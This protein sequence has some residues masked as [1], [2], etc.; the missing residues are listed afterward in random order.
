[1]TNDDTWQHISEIADDLIRR[2]EKAN[3]RTSDRLSA[4]IGPWNGIGPLP[5]DKQKTAIAAIQLLKD[6]EDGA[7][8]IE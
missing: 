7:A 5:P 1:M 6:I 8:F 3:K 4:N 2:H